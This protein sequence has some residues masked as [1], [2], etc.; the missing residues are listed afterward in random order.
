MFGSFHLLGVPHVCLFRLSSVG[1]EREDFYDQIPVM[2][3]EMLYRLNDDNVSVL[4]A[5]HAAFTALSSKVPA[6]ELVQHVE[7]MKNLIASMVSEARRRKGGVGDGEF[8]LPGFNM[9]KGRFLFACNWI[10]QLDDTALQEYKIRLRR[11]VFETIS[12]T[13]WIRFD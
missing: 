3:R 1:S 8:L 7:F 4:K 2:M 10:R 11:G 13:D 12:L 9:P 5:N 6:E